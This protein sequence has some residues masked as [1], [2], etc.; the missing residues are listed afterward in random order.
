MSAE[1]VDQVERR[2]YPRFRSELLVNLEARFSTSFSSSGWSTLTAVTKDVSRGG[3]L[4]RVDEE[5]AVGTECVVRFLA[6][7]NRILPPITSG[8]VLRTE[9]RHSG[10]EVAV[11]FT[12]SLEVL[13]LSPESEAPWSTA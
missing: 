6:P 11:E 12:T 13:E 10:T 2:R 8:V 3:L 7:G 5:L 1:S 4:A 9:T